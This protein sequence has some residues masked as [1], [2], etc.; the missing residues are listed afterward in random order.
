MATSKKAEAL[1]EQITKATNTWQND[2]MSFVSESLN[3]DPSIDGHKILSSKIKTSESLA[4]T[5]D[6]LANKLLDDS[7]SDDKRKTV[8][9][10]IKLLLS[11][12][13][14]IL[15]I[16]STQPQVNSSDKAKHEDKDE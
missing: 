11:F 8:R 4:L 1:L 7:L 9:D 16:D 13:K 15:Q 5:I 14:V 6:K 10:D 12:Q 2:I 3:A